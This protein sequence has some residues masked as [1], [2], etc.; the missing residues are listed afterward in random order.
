MPADDDPDVKTYTTEQVAEFCQVTTETV[1]RW[2]NE[3]K[4]K[5]VKLDN[6]WRIIRRDLIQFLNE[7]YMD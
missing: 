1:R 4:L 6:A 3:G 7:R 5:G 2:L